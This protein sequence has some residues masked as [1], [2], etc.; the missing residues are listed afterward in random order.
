MSRRQTMPEPADLA[1]VIQLVLEDVKP[2][3][4]IVHLNRLAAARELRRLVE[5][6]VVAARQLVEGELTRR[7]EHADIVL[8]RLPANLPTRPIT[9]LHRRHQLS[10]VR[11]NNAAAAEGGAL[12]AQLD[13]R[14]VREQRTDGV[15]RRVVQ[16]VELRDR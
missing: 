16:M 5:P 10:L 8:E 6:R 11:Q 7:L 14:D 9:Q 2:L 12:V 3:E 4:V 1:T 15:A 13:A